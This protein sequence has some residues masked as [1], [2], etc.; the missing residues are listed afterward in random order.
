MAA[1]AHGAMLG[2]W[3][4]PTAAE[5]AQIYCE[6][7]RTFRQVVFLAIKA[8]CSF[9]SGFILGSLQHLCSRPF[10]FD[11]YRFFFPLFPGRQLGNDAG[12]FFFCCLLK[13]I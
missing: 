10:L 1:S 4:Q 6:V 12:G 13:K 7:P 3:K 11:L 5:M 8:V 2:D 9:H